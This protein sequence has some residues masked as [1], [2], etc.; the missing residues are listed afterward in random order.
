MKKAP[1]TRAGQSKVQRATK[2]AHDGA[3]KDIITYPLRKIKNNLGGYIMNFEAKHPLI[4]KEIQALS[5]NEF[6]LFQN[7][8]DMQ[9]KKRK[10]SEHM[11]L[12]LGVDLNYINSLA[13]GIGFILEDVCDYFATDKDSLKLI[14]FDRNGRKIDI[15]QDVIWNIRSSLS[16]W[17][18]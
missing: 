14:D 11:S 12:D 1:C 17:V 6:R 7:Y 13:E 16:K 9:A 10:L 18:N 15:V 2:T 4:D 8:I 5:D 3:D